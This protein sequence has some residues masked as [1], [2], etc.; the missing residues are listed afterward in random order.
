MKKKIW[1]VIGIAALYF[2]Y[3]PL[4]LIWSAIDTGSGMERSVT[5][6]KTVKKDLELHKIFARHGM[7]LTGDG[8]S[9][10]GKTC[11][12]CFV[13]EDGTN[14]RIPPEVEEYLLN[15]PDLVKGCRIEVQIMAPPN[16]GYYLLRKN[17]FSMETFLLNKCGIMFPISTG[18]A[19]LVLS[20]SNS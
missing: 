16:N 17:I 8:A 11:Q 1:I 14:A 2:I 3:L 15:N 5:L 9:W 18:I 7:K 12:I 10:R 6:L 13:V 20:F 19:L 4:S